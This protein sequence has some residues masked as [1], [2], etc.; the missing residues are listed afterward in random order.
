MKRAMIGELRE[1]L[2]REVAI[3][4]WVH[5]LRNQGGIRF[6]V[7]RDITGFIQVVAL[8]ENPEAFQIVGG[9][10]LESVVKVVGGPT[11]VDIPNVARIN[12]GGLTSA[13]M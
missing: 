1:G 12:C 11:K 13:T 8:K 6:I 9:L 3:C 10:S 2:D 5:A 4:G 7:V